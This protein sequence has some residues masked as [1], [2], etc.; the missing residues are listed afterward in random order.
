MIKKRKSPKADRIAPEDKRIA[1]IWTRVSTKEQAEHNLS[2]GTQEKAC[3]EYAERNHIEV[4]SVLGQT[5]ESAKEEGKLYQEMI[6]Y[7]SSHRRINTI[8]VYSFDRFSR[9]GAEAMITKEFLKAKGIS[10]VS[11]TQP[12]DDDNAAGQF[13]QNIIF[14]FNQFENNLR[15]DK[16]VAGMVACLEKGDW[17]S[18]PPLG[19]R[20]VGHN[21]SDHR[22]EITKE[23]ELIRKAFHWKADEGQSEVVIL[24]RLQAEGLRLYK[25]QLSRV[26]H[27]S[28]YCGIIEHRLLNG[29]VVKGNHPALINEETYNRANGIQTHSGY[30]HKTDV[31]EIPLRMFIRCPNCGKHLSGYI[32]Q[33]KGLWYYRCTTKGCHVN[34]SAK[35][36]HRAFADSLS[37]LPLTPQA[38]D[39]AV[40][41]I[42]NFLTSQQSVI[43]E[44][45]A[46]LSAERDTLE[47][48]KKEVISRYGIGLIP[49]DVYAI[50]LDELNR[51]LE[52]VTLSIDELKNKTSNHPLDLRRIFVMCCRAG[53]YWEAGNLDTR[54]RIQ[55]WAYPCEIVWNPETCGPRTV[56]V[57]EPLRISRLISSSYGSETNKKRD[58][59]CDLSPCVAGRGLEPLTSGL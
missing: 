11:V 47:R 13:M 18:R 57:C 31:P 32:V 8:I 53:E 58:K 34:I 23:G 7:V 33:K 14:L 59:P 43:K 29:K 25:Q 12:I 42:G 3:K 38:L 24:A 56:A 6:R 48:Q 10:V 46:G 30:S 36:A 50:T 16:C 45:A 49:A 28:F 27:N 51:K 37:G 26:L 17:F 5:N 20:K 54:R 39:Y 52:V 19:Y 9:A 44:R 2:L 41:V 40:S 15:K 21:K 55:K 1:V 35:T 22:L 4:D